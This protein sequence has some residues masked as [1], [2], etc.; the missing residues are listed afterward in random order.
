MDKN[1][2]CIILIFTNLILPSNCVFYIGRYKEIPVP[3][4]ENNEGN[5]MK[6][7]LWRIKRSLSE[8]TKNENTAQGDNQKRSFGTRKYPQ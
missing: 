2:I 7:D 5:Y 1:L 8:N 4:E 3:I 6:N